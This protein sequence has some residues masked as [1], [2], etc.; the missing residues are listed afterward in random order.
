MRGKQQA[1]TED[2][3][4]RPLTEESFSLLAIDTVIFA[5][6]VQAREGWG[7]SG[8]VAQQKA[9]GMEVAGQERR[10]KSEDSPSPVCLTSTLGH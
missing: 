2:G 10:V 8:A 3:I 9:G 6:E 7:H 4:W 5:L 1:D